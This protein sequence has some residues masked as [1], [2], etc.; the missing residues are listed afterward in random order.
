MAEGRVRQLLAGG[1]ISNLPM[2][3]SFSNSPVLEIR[4]GT[5]GYT[6]PAYKNREVVYDVK[7]EMYS[8]GIVILEVLT[9]S[10]QWSRDVYDNIIRLHEI[11]IPEGHVTAD[12][13]AG[14]WPPDCV[15][16][17]FDLVKTYCISQ[18]HYRYDKMQSVMRRLSAIR[19]AFCPPPTSLE[20]VFRQR[21]EA[22]IERNEELRMA[23]D[24]TAIAQDPRKCIVCFDDEFVVTAGV[25]C[26]HGHF[27]CDSCFCNVTVYQCDLRPR[28]AAK[29]CKIV[30]CA[31]DCDEAFEDHV[32]A[33]HAGGVGFD[34]FYRAKTVVAMEDLTRQYEIQLEE[35]K[36]ELQNA[37][38][39]GE[40]PEVVR[41]RHRNHII[42]ELL[43]MKC[44]NPNCRRVFIMDND[45]DD[46]F[47]MT[48]PFCHH[49]FCGWCLLYFEEDDGHGH[50]AGCRPEDS[51][52]RGLFPQRENDGS[53]SAKQCFDMVHGPRRATIV[54]AYLDE[55]G[56]QGFDRDAVITAVEAQWNT[57][58]DNIHL[59]V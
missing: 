49:N 26:S 28:F 43:Q 16:Q 54:K 34:A 37:Q 52:P 56:L 22:L 9:D 53:H 14:A 21:V 20:S 57:G 38:R 19:A 40:N 29:N 1:I 35:L 12:A 23:R 59:R 30:C 45:F 55:Q 32:V 8:F 24:V 11:L 6:C 41:L 15:Q 36:T 31:T 25:E 51:Q 33:S 44:P 13:R 5:H 27:V 48:C 7:C 3:D 46:C 4:F 39:L 42:E 58:D 18:Y 2:T 47:R 10:L 50:T 17:L